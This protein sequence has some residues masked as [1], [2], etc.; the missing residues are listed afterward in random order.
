MF[1]QF[2]LPPKAEGRCAHRAPGHHQ[3]A[4]EKIDP[5]RTVSAADNC[6]KPLDK[7]Y[8]RPYQNYRLLSAQRQLCPIL[9]CDADKNGHRDSGWSFF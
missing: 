3:S 6:Y 9:G 4:T 5:L 2:G 1:Y 8:L 7:R